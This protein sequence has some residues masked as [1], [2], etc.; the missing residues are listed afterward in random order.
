MTLRVTLDTNTLP[1]EEWLTDQLRAR[2]EFAV[3]S[4]TSEETK[5]TSFSVQIVPLE[6]IPK[7]L[8]FGD[9]AFGFGVFGGGTD[10]ECLR[11]AL[12]IISAGAFT[13]PE[14]TEGLTD[15]QRRQRRDAEI[16]C[17]HVRDARNI[18]VTRDATGFIRSGRRA[19]FESEF[20]VRI[21]TPEEFV[22]LEPAT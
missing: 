5:G 17:T 3:I 22:A 21:L 1:V 6:E 12:K 13:D 20:A 15:G 19:Q 7:H 14:R 18:F 16:I 2:Y 10:K 11:K 8:A 4:V 9:R